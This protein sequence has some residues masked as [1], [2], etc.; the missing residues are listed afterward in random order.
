MSDIALKAELPE[1]ISNDLLA[2]I[3]CI[4]GAVLVTNFVDVS[5]GIVTFV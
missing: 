3:G 5:D 1:A 2:Y 4:S